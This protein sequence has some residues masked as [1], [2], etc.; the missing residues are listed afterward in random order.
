MPKRIVVA[1]TGASGA[2]LGVRLLEAL[3]NC[4]A[5][6]HLIISEAGKQ[7]LAIET[8]YAV[9]QVWAMASCAYDDAD[10]TSPLASGSFP[11]D[12]MVIIPCS[13][14]TLAGVASGYAATLIL[15]AA[16]VALKERRP[17]IMAVREAPLSAIHLENML[18]VTRAGAV[19]MPPVPAF[20]TKP[21][22]VNDICD[23]FVARIMAGFALSHPKFTSWQ[24]TSCNE[25]AERQTW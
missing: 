9:E 10:L 1:M 25:S 4:G 14:K 11:T 17:L 23:Q 15:R 20:Y 6:T 3:H 2:I 21:Q 22:T 19:I 18:R 5:E 24:G 12:G 16:D 13:V 7:T 8:E